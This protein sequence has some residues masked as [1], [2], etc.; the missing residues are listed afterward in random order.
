MLVTQ[1]PLDNL[2]PLPTSTIIFILGGPGAGKGTQCQNLVKEFNFTHLSAGDLL[3]EE[4]QRP[5]SP[6]GELI[7]DYIANGQ[8]VPME[9]TI[10]LLHQVLILIGNED[11]K[12]NKILDRWISPKDGPSS[13]V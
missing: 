5:N 12:V 7:N 2:S 6:Y 13:K 1:S 11:F 9:I 3:R 8:I 4:R 10:A